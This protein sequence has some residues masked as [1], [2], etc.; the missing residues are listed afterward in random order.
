MRERMRQ[1]KEQKAGNGLSKSNSKRSRKSKQ[2]LTHISTGQTYRGTEW[3]DFP[4]ILERHGICIY[5]GS[6]VEYLP[7]IIA[8]RL[9]TSFL[10]Y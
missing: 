4:R 8:D 9:V 7:T 6:Q 5:L 3:K 2:C 10:S 1:R